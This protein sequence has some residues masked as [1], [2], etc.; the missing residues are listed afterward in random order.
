M[1]DYRIVLTMEGMHDD[2]GHVRL[3]TFVAEVQLLMRM[4]GKIDRR[5][6]KGKTANHFRVINLSHSSPARV[7]IGVCQASKAMDTR[8]AVGTMLADAISGID[9]GTVPE[10]LDRALLQDLRNLA[11]PVGDKLRA[12]TLEADG[13]VIDLTETFAKRID[14]A[15][16]G[17]EVA[18]GTIEGHLEQINIHDGANVFSIYPAFG[19]AK[20]QCRFKNEILDVAIA[21]VGAEVAVT[22]KLNYKPNDPYPD[23]IEV[24]DIDIFPPESELPS[25]DDLRGIAPEATGDQSSEDFIAE[26]RDA[27]N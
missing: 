11:R 16:T 1:T 9:S 21:A 17:D 6:S 15:L 26:R 19:P 20:V 5:V 14:L 22:G 24:D 3:P 25:F 8:A 10:H 7:E 13:K 2:D 18:F 12:A 23:F 27:W 4:V